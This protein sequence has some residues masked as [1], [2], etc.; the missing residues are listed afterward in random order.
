MSK[1]F[2]NSMSTFF[3]ENPD[4]ENFSVSEST[5]MNTLLHQPSLLLNKFFN[6]L[7]NIFRENAYRDFYERKIW[8][9]HEYVFVD[10]KDQNSICLRTY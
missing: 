2:D 4:T 9:R 5:R 7:K 10:N 3:V 6:R 1:N 8:Q